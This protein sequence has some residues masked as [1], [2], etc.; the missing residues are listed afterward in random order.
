MTDHEMLNTILSHT[1][2]RVY[3]NGERYME[4]ETNGYDTL[5]LEFDEESN[6]TKIY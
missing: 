6:L 4:I 5:S 2:Y 3:V 1:D